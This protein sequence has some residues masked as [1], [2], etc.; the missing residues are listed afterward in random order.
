MPQHGI[1][2]VGKNLPAAV[3]TAVLLDKACR[4]Q[5]TAM[6]AWFAP[7]LVVA[8]GEPGG[9]ITVSWPQA[10]LTARRAIAAGTHL[11]EVHVSL[12]AIA[13][14]TPPRSAARVGN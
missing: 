13:A 4:T 7:A 3:M 5:L 12:A 8:A 9:A 6:A 14:I 11:D 1:V 10:A 2:A